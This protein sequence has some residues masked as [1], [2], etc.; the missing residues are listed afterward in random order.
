MRSDPLV[1]PWPP[2]GGSALT[3]MGHLGFRVGLS[4]CNILHFPIFVHFLDVVLVNFG[5][6]GRCC[7]L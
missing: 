3:L 6:L 4:N 2:G 7:K 5:F 1:L